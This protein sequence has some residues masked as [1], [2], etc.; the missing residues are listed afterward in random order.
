MG[1]E[2]DIV[3]RANGL[4]VA[5]AASGLPEVEVGLF[6]FLALAKVGVMETDSRQA[7]SASSPESGEET[8]SDSGHYRTNGQTPPT[9]SFLV[10]RYPLTGTGPG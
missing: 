2:C 4:P 3:Y 7:A 9:N 8:D 10:C 1:L 5:N 6:H